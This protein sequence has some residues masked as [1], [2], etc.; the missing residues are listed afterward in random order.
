MKEIESMLD[1]KIEMHVKRVQSHLNKDFFTSIKHN[2]LPVVDYLDKII[3]IED[4]YRVVSK[5]TDL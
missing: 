4:V 3:S 5:K 2:G 1:K